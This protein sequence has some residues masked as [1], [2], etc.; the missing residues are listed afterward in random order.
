VLLLAAV[1][2]MQ[3]HEIAA[4]LSVPIGTVM[5]APVAGPR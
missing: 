5:V 2:E 4:A 3:Y 1:E